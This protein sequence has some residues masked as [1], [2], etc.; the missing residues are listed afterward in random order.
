MKQSVSP[1][2]IEPDSERLLP[3]GDEAGTAPEDRAFR[4]DIQGMRAVAV[5]LVVCAHVG[6]P[7]MG[8]GV[9]G[10]DVFFVISGFVITGILLRERAATG[11][12]G[13]VAFYGR[14]ARRI[15]RWQYS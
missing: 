12:T 9:I 10:V 1:S 4:P 5:V 11:H 7:R 13:L 3:S 14:R 2:F 6:I 15:I 8:Y